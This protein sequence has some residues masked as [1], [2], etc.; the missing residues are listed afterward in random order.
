MTR[1]RGM[2]KQSYEPVDPLQTLTAT[3]PGAHPICRS[4][5]HRLEGATAGSSARSGHAE[6]CGVAGYVT[7]VAYLLGQD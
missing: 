2:G 4:R 1:S 3:Y 5:N 7:S 6:C